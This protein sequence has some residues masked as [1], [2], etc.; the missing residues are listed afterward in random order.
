MIC[1]E[2]GNEMEMIFYEDESG[3][4]IHWVCYYCEVKKQEE[5]NEVST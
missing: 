2:C 3:K 4:Y 1:P 5:L